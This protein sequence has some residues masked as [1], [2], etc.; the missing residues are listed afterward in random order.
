MATAIAVARPWLHP[1]PQRKSVLRL[2]QTAQGRW[3]VSSTDG[4]TGGTFFDRDQA[5]RFARR[6]G[7]GAPV[8]VLARA[9]SA[10]R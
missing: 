5:L 3:S 10:L 6:E 1:A 2:Y 8:V 7:D 9:P 4:L